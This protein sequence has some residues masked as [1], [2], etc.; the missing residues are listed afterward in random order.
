MA[1]LDVTGHL[2]KEAQYIVN[3]S[4]EISK[5]LCNVRAIVQR[6]SYHM[7]KVRE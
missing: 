4:N 6:V 2:T 1:C 7:P 3:L 5:P